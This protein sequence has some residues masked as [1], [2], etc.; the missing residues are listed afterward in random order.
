M[1][2]LKGVIF[3]V[4]NVLAK[5]GELRPN[6]YWLEETGKLVRFLQG[7]KIELVVM[8]NR[9]W[10]I[11]QDNKPSEPAK[12]YLERTWRVKLS[13]YRCNFG[14]M[15]AKQSP[16]ALEHIRNEKGWAANE[17][18]YVGNSDADMQAAVNSKTLLLNA[19]WYANQM[20]Y[21]FPFDEPK[22][23]ARFIDVFCL[24]EPQ[25]AFRV[26]ANPLS[27]FTLATFSTM[28]EPH[29]EY[30]ENFRRNIKDEYGHDEQFWAKYLCSNLYFSGLYEC[31]NY[32]TSYPCHQQ[33][34]F[35]EV[36]I[37]PV[38]RFA[39]CFRANYIHDLI[40]RH[41]TS[42]QSHK[43]RDTVDHLNQLRTIRL[44]RN[45][46]KREGETY[47]SSPLKQ[48]KTVLVIDDVCSKGMS[49]EAARAYLSATGCNVI[50]VALLKALKHGYEAIH[51][52]TVSPYQA[53]SP[54]TVSVRQTYPYRNHVLDDSAAIALRDRLRRYGA[55]DW[56]QGI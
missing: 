42:T 39:K 36:L 25:W 32:I 26:E 56:P 43:N 18:L 5:E 6:R 19:R 14:G 1:A 37:E 3:G 4:E 51:P 30:S 38:T 12:D 17:T 52:V 33:G 24:R 41:K 13:W 23:V 11:G 31:V 50:S 44:N 10:R 47:K 9:D 29:I 27:V 22:G 15:P 48:G 2:Q 45:P 8:T 20:D 54:S 46:T 7:K 40:V 49:F 21:G 28:Y 53:N 35:P 55:W 16:E 34:T